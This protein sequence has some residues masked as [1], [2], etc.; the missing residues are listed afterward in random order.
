MKPFFL[1]LKKNFTKYQIQDIINMS[2]PNSIRLYQI[3]KTHKDKQSQYRD[4]AVITYSLD[5]LKMRLGLDDQKAYSQYGNFKNRV[6]KTAQ[7]QLRE[8]THIYFDFKEKKTGRKVTD[9]VFSIYNNLP[10]ATEE[11][12]INLFSS[13]MPD[14]KIQ[15]EIEDS[16]F[17][18]VKRWGINRSSVEQLCKTYDKAYIEEK[19]LYTKKWLN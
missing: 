9:V 15:K 2:S 6:L 17:E 4:I 11:V 3:L 19:I 16:I 10:N 7:E 8:N 1:E 14:E 12:L 13:E 5:E 18:Q